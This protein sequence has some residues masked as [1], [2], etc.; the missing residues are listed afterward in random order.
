MQR[1]LDNRFQSIAGM[2]PFRDLGRVGNAVI[3]GVG[4]ARIRAIGLFGQVVEAIAVQRVLI[5]ILNPV[6]IRVLDQRVS[7]GKEL[8]EVVKAVVVRIID[9]IAVGLAVRVV[10]HP[11][12]THRAIK[13]GPDTVSTEV[14]PGV[15]LNVIGTVAVQ[16]SEGLVIRVK[17]TVAIDI[18]PV[19]RR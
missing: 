16:V 13:R 19:D 15:I 9:R 17:D 11:P 7:A 1:T 12:G 14:H 8:V 4:Q 5:A 6:T 2:G 3:V 10:S 18:Q